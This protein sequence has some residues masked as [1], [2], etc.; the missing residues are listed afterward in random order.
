MQRAPVIK[1]VP[2]WQIINRKHITQ[3]IN[4][5][6]ITQIINRTHITQILVWT[7]FIMF[8]LNTF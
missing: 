5:K 4:R 3:I 6:H 8:D 7:D 2:L 1:D